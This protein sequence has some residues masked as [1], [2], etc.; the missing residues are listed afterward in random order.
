M[1]K[2]EHN[3]KAIMYPAYSTHHGMLTLYPIVIWCLNKPKLI[4][5]HCHPVQIL[6][7]WHSIKCIIEDVNTFIIFCVLNMLTNC[8]SMYD[9]KSGKFTKEQ[10]ISII[11]DQDVQY[12]VCQW[13]GVTDHLHTQC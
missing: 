2:A 6:E 4:N 1:H 11:H 7:M 5:L 3:L 10:R 12:C 9:Q 8:D 13:S